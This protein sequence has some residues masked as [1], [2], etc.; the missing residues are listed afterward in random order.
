[1][2]RFFNVRIEHKSGKGLLIIVFILLFIQLFIAHSGYSGGEEEYAIIEKD[3]KKGLVNRKGRVLIPPEYEDLGWTNGGAQ[4][5]EDVIGFKKN[6]LWGILNTKNE[7]VTEPVYTSLTK[8]NENWIVASKKLPYNSN[9]VYGVINAKGKAEI[10]FQ[11]HKL[12]VNGDQLIASKNEEGAFLYGIL[13]DRSKPVLP[14]KYDRIEILTEQLY[15]VYLD[16]KI[17]VC[18][19]QG[20]NLTDFT[21]DS[22]H[23]N[24]DKY[25]ITYQ[26]GKQGIINV[27]S[28]K[29]MHPQYKSVSLDN[30]NIRGQHFQKWSAFD[31]TNHLITTYHYDQILPKGISIYSVSVGDAQALIH[32]SDSLLTPF[33][34][35][36]IQAHFGKWIAIKKDGKSGVMD[37]EGNTFLEPVYDSIK[38]E[39]G[40]FLVKTKTHGERGWSMVNDSGKVKTDQVYQEIDWLGDSYFKAK[41]DGFWGIV[42]T[43]GKETIYC[44]YDSI[45]QYTEGKL[46]V[47][48]LGEDG[49]LNLDGSWEILP[50][51]KDIEIVDPM[52]YLIRSP[53]GSY[54]AFYPETKDFTAEYFLY[55][56]GERY[57]EKT[58]DQK[59]GLLNEKGKRVIK[60]EFNEIS[61]L[62]EDSIY[63]AKADKGY[64]FITKSGEI[65]ISGDNRF[66]EIRP[67]AEEFIGVKIDDRWGFVDMNGKLRIANQYENIGPFNEGLAPIKILGRWGYID[68]REDIIVQPVYDT[69]Y[70]FEGG[71]CEV[72]KKGKFGL[73]NAAG[74]I[75]LECEY[76]NIKRI[77]SGGFLI[78]RDG[79]IGLV[80]KEGRLKILPRFDHVKDLSNGFVIAERKGKYGLL[81]NNGVSIIP[82]IYENLI[83]DQ[84]ND[85]YL[86]AEASEWEE[87]QIQ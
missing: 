1:M 79:K 38:Y 74:Q 29:V 22:V 35:V 16:E 10:A 42:N 37:F 23:L 57:L 46:L 12:I 50:Q 31:N 3:H 55:K 52:R 4:L 67:M 49:I 40:V 73:I 61:K 72:V 78:E 77:K 6:G 80:N 41:R 39:K 58:L 24:N 13:D 11:Y 87:I 84:I 33:S 9:I 64:S 44:K 21:L 75:A 86:A 60:P 2:A 54:V 36:E 19:A 18:N 59:F 47:K 20:D 32:E 66:Q 76:D 7:K 65:L 25:I 45:V 68:K 34:D 82:M 14:L 63:Y 30:E 70:R 15:E 26:N 56:H 81:S 8:F 17:A 28:Q 5:L 48:F 43:Q 51:Q 85:L 27:A 53:Y 83:Y 71:L 69:V 62:Q